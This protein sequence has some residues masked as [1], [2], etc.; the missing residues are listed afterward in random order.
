MLQWAATRQ[1]GETLRTLVALRPEAYVVLDPTVAFLGQTV[2]ALLVMQSLA[3]LGL[4]WQ[5]HQRLAARPFGTP[6]GRFREFRFADG[7]V[8]AVVLGVTVWITPLLAG[9]K[10]AA[11]NLL[12]VV[13]TLYL[14]RGA[15]VV[16]AFALTVGVSP[17]ALVVACLAAALLAVPLLIVVPGLATLGMT[18]TWLE[19]R[20]RLA[21]RP[22]AS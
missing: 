19:F 4:A 2:P 8:W 17:M 1:A 15:A 21:G 9:L 11:L 20:R 16:V 12:V 22:N 3:G 13:G 10:G 6:L 18:D 7:W 14:L 5:W